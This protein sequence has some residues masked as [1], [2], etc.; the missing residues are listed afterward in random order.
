MAQKPTGKIVIDVYEH[1]DT[2]AVFTGHIPANAVFTSKLS[3]QRGYGNYL[4][5]RGLEER[6]MKLDKDRTVAIKEQEKSEVERK[7][8]AEKLRAKQ[9]LQDKVKRLEIELTT[10]E[11]VTL[12]GLT[13]E[14][15]GERKKNVDLVKAEISKLK[16]TK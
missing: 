12:K 13:P 9:E 6:K 7:V 15:L 8:E 3:I 5:T 1:G 14:E 16:Q 10:Y 11:G 2:K 4:Q